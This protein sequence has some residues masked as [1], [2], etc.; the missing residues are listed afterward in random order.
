MSRTFYRRAVFLIFVSAFISSAA[1]ADTTVEFRKTVPLAPGTPV[2]VNN[3]NG[4]VTISAWDSTYAD[5]FAVKR[6]KY[7]MN[8]IDKVSIEVSTSSGLD[9]RT[10]FDKRGLFGSSPRVT[11]NYTIRLPRSTNLKSAGTVNG[12]ITIRGT[13]GEA[14]LHTT[15]GSI[16][17]EDVLHIAEASSTNGSITINGARSVSQAS[18]TNGSISATFTA[19]SGASEFETVN[20]SISLTIPSGTNANLEFRTVN[21]SIKIPD[22]IRLGRGEISRKRLSGQIGSGGPDISAHTVNGSV[23]LRAQ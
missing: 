9:I 16:K 13:G 22:G 17:S 3:T 15:N 19:G 2:T 8:E 20:G 18:T 1:L 14:S 6:S 5:I 21:G 7:G 11:V 10:R 4:G 12:G 23:T